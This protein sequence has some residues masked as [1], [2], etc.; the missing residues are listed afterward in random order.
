MKKNIIG[1]M[2]MTKKPERS[3]WKRLDLVPKLLCIL[4][5][6]M[7]W[8]LAVNVP[9]DETPSQGQDA[10]AAVQVSVYE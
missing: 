2:M 3:L 6:L 8:L 4:L 9:S 10:Q 1:H 7:I 5:A